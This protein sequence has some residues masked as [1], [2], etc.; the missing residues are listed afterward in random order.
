[1]THSRWT[2][3]TTVRCSPN[4]KNEQN[5]HSRLRQ[6]LF[7]TYLNFIL[8]DPSLVSHTVGI[9][10]SSVINASL[11]SCNCA[12]INAPSFSLNAS[13][14]SSLTSTSIEADSSVTSTSKD[15]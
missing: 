6:N 13:I 5:S 14:F 2:I 4:Y 9:V 3:S 15:F 7:L 12:A 11:E 1:M 8:Q 10:N